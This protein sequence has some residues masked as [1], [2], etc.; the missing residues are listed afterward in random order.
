M[1]HN[2]PVDKPNE[3]GPTWHGTK[4]LQ[5]V[6]EPSPKHF[7]SR[8]E[9]SRAPIVS[10]RAVLPI[11]SPL[12]GTNYARPEEHI[13]RSMDKYEL[14]VQ[15]NNGSENCS[16]QESLKRSRLFVGATGTYD[17]S[18]VKHTGVTNQGDVLFRKQAVSSSERGRW[19]CSP[20][21]RSSPETTATAIQAFRELSGCECDASTWDGRSVPRWF[22]ACFLPELQTR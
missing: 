9:T 5:T 3:L 1:G 8:A 22:P 13:T 2:W 18:M 14:L 11:W 21:S 16:A 17:P 7:H 6:L 20:F 12:T 15:R 10:C 19:L 4:G